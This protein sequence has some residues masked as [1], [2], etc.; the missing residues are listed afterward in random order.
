MKLTLVYGLMFAGKS[1][2]CA[3]KYPDYTFYV[4]SFTDRGYFSRDKSVDDPRNIVKFGTFLPKL[5]DKMVIDEGQ[6]LNDVDLDNIINCNEDIHIVVACLNSKG[7]VRGNHYTWR[8]S[9][10]LLAH[11]PEIIHLQSTCSIAGCNG[12][13]VMHID[14]SCGG[15]YI[16]DRGYRV[17]CHKCLSAMRVDE[18]ERVNNYLSKLIWKD[19]FSR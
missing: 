12:E 14:V 9:S 16:G 8:V 6:F 4:P 15:E 19:K 13:G 10:E 3:K 18:K 11:S 17:M 5:H 1:S 2:Y 7:Y